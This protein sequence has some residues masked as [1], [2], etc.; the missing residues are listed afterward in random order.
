MMVPG[1]TDPATERGYIGFHVRGAECDGPRD[2]R[3]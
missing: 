3:R 2:A 1:V